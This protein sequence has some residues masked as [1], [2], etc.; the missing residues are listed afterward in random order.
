MDYIKITLDEPHAIQE[1]SQFAMSIVREHFDPIIG[2]AQNDYMMER[3]QTVEAIKKQLKDGYQYYVIRDAKQ[4]RIG[5]LAFYRRKD[6]MYL[7]KFYL[8]KEQRGKGFSKDMLQFVIEQTKKEGLSSITLNVNRENDAALAYEKLG[9]V[10]VR[11]EKNDI[12]NGFF[13]DDFVY[14]YVM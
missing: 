10:K 9:F 14:E 13:M 6:E 3:F 11:E 2:T 12:G 8:Q 4:K 7:S 5:F 1:L